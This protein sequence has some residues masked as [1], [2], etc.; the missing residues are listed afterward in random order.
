M[1]DWLNEIILHRKRNEQKRKNRE[2]MAEKGRE[3]ESCKTA[4]PAYVLV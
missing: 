3:L 4:D 1:N 2:R